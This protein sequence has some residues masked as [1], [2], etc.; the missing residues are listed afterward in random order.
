MNTPF[1]D[2]TL[3]L[4]NIGKDPKNHLDNNLFNLDPLP[5]V[6][7]HIRNNLSEQ[8]IQDIRIISEDL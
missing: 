7:E 4:V 5:D 6:W 2:L 3:K 8:Q 1:E